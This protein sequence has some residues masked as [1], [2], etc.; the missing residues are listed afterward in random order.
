M[1]QLTGN[2]D[3][4]GEAELCDWSGGVGSGVVQSTKAAD[5]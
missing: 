2:F 4:T 1:E 5:V 3:V